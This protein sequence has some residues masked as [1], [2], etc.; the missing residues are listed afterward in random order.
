MGG[1]VPIE[2]HPQD[3]RVKL[4]EDGNVQTLTGKMGTGGG[5]VPLLLEIESCL[6]PWDVQSRRIYGEDGKW[7]SLYA[8]E[9]GGHG[10][11]MKL[12]PVCYNGENLTSPLNKQN[13]LPGDPCHTLG[14]D[15]RNYVLIPCTAECP[16][17]TLLVRSG[18]EGGGKGSLI[19]EDKSATLSTQTRCTQ[20]LFVPV[21]LDLYNQKTGEVMNALRAGKG[22]DTIPCVG[23]LKE[24]I[25]IA[26]KATRYKG[27]GDTR[28]EDGAGNGLGIGEADAPAYTLTA[29]DRH[30][31]AYSLDKA[32][33]NQ[34]E[35]ALYSIGV[36]EDVAHTVTAGWQPPAVSYVVPDKAGT[37]TAKMAKGTG[38]PAGDECQNLVAWYPEYI[39]RRLMPLECGRLQG[40]PDG[41]T[42]GLAEAEPDDALIDYWEAVFE[43]HRRLTE[44]PQ[45]NRRKRSQVIKWLKDPC[46]DTALYKMW[47]NGI[48]LPCAA[49]VMK[50][51]VME[52]QRGGQ[53]VD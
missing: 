29:A 49:F 18:C 51:I 3:C 30:A 13:P 34:G 2:S 32:A 7:P 47:G 35:N 42:D 45:E 28:N 16:P 44:E 11:V 26:D 22:G 52:L 6:T 24:V 27:G 48:A 25:P 9:G 14:T 12:M 20:A 43:E 1:G 38:G 23:E 50:G 40:F 46:S 36:M 15:S 37:L 41:W 33:Y 17:L 10:Y 21:A 8:G 4:C 53:G 31:V 5:N 39:V 19:Q